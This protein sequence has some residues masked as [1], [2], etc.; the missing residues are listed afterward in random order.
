MEPLPNEECFSEGV[1]KLKSIVGVLTSKHEY[2]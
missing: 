1:M 2:T